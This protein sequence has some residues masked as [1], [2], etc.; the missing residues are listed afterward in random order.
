M[1]RL[2]IVA[3]VLSLL[4]GGGAMLPSVAGA[5][6]WIGWVSDDATHV[7]W[8]K[9]IE[10]E[11][12][13]KEYRMVFLND[14]RTPQASIVHLLQRAATAYNEQNPMLA[15]QFVSEALR[16][17]EEGVRKNYYSEEDVQ[18]IIALIKRYAPTGATA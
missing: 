18:P 3:C 1:K 17:L 8:V 4:V 15:E 13:K 16:V 5:A 10:Q 11:L 12:N 7:A 9:Q 6:D 14:P 2:M